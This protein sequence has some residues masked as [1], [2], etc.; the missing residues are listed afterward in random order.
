MLLRSTIR[1]FLAS[2]LVLSFVSCASAPPPAKTPP[3]AAPVEKGPPSVN[4]LC[5]EGAKALR[6]DK[7][8]VP[9]GERPA[10]VALTQGSIWVLF[11][12]GRLLQLSRGGDSLSVHTHVLPGG[13][14]W[15]RLAVDPVDESVWAVS[16]DH[17]NLYK[18]SP[19]GQVS[20]IRLQRKIEGTGGFYSLVV[21]RDAIYAQPTCADT[22]VWRLDRAGK[23]LATSFEAP[24]RE[25]DEAPAEAVRV[26]EGVTEKRRGC[27]NV[28]MEKDAEGHIL[29]WD[30]EQKGTFQV[31]EQGNWTPSESRLFTQLRD[32]G[33]AVSFKGVA[34]GE[35][36]EQWYFTDVVG[37]LFFWK[38][39]PVFLGSITAKE[40]QLGNDTVLLLPGENG[41]REVL[42]ACNGFPI[43]HAVTDATGYAAISE[44]FLILGEMA[45]APDL[46]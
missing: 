17:F 20:V 3:P 16:Q 7:I 37:D 46:P 2:G 41:F 36:T 6:F 38:G 5:H 4:L 21:G 11:A 31:D 8:G 30:D 45:G 14:G 22:A 33:P 32:P 29:V 34:I 43:R 26:T 40:R 27:A 25:D 42:M 28:Y 23:V 9:S 24:K 15:S 12:Q 18:V 19:Q 10:D 39:K 35:K 44:G 1:L 13:E